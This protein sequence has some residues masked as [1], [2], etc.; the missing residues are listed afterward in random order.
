MIFQSDARSDIGAW[1]IRPFEALDEAIAGLRRPGR[2]D[3]PLAMHAGLHVV[4]HDG[5]EYVVEQL[6]GSLY[7]DL[8]S[9]LN[10]TPI[11]EFRARDR[12]GW[13]VTIP[14]TAFRG[15]T[16]DVV[17]EAVDR[18]NHLEGEPFLAEDCTDLIE[19][20]FGMR[21]LFADSPT[22]RLLGI[23]GRLGDPA[24]PLLRPDVPQAERARRLL[25]TSALYRLPDPGR[26]AD[27][28]RAHVWAG[29]VTLAALALLA[30]IL[31]LLAYRRAR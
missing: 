16:D 15:V 19:R 14:A 29:R 25:R 17:H 11:E 24:M 1:F 27:P 18:L 4:L 12:G 3:A 20:V 9:G 30:S 6:V 8:K 23:R 31:A 2:D 10:W 22:L 21:Q 28:H 13:D 26:G 5:R 7:E